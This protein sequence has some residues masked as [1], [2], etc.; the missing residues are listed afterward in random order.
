MLCLDSAPPDLALCWNLDVFMTEQSTRFTLFMMHPRI[1]MHSHITL[2]QHLPNSHQRFFAFAFSDGANEQEKFLFCSLSFHLPH[3]TCLYI[4]YLR[5]AHRRSWLDE[6]CAAFPISSD[7]FFS[8][9]S[10][11]RGYTHLW[12][13]RRAVL[14]DLAGD[15]VY[16]FFPF[17]ARHVDALCGRLGLH[18]LSLLQGVCRKEFYWGH[19]GGA[20]V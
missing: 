6:H 13:F 17:F 4:T 3:A 2:S 9:D 16:F 12:L 8:S 10:A 20:E 5:M 7:V 1:D 19:R 11:S 15:V 18:F 14:F